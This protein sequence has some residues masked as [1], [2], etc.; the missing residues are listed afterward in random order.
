M[1]RRRVTGWQG[2]MCAAGLVWMLVGCE[3]AQPPPAPP[4][5]AVTVTHPIEREVIEWDEYT[6]R[7]D[8]VESVDVRARVS[9]LIES[10]SF[11]EGANVKKGDMLFT[12][13]VR[14]FRA[15]LNSK[16]ADVARAK[17]QLLQASSDLKRFQEAV[18]T[19]AVSAKDLDTAQAAFDRANAELAAARAAQDAAQLN[20][21]W[22]YITAP[23]DGRISN[24]RVDE[25]NL[26]T[27]GAGAATL[28][29]TIVSL[30]PIYCYVTVDENSVLKY[31]QLAREG[32]RVSARYAQIPTFL[33][34]ASETGFPHE[35]VVDFVD[36]QIDPTTGTVKGRGVYPNPDGFLQ[37]GMFAR[38]RIPGSGR[39]RALLI[40]DVAIGAD[41]NRRFVMTV[42]ADDIVEMHTVK[43]GALFGDLRA[44]ESGISKDDRV[45]IRGLQRARPGAKVNPTEQPIPESALA[46][47]A[48][49]SPTTQALPATR[50]V[51]TTLPSTMPTTSTAPAGAA[52]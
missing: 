11:K 48:P 50:R 1:M 27:G 26:I 23:I 49:G 37:P 20:V 36:N 35:G 24:K 40:P 15:E 17:A 5:P 25:G 28:L 13:D 52:R 2:M 39:Y 4:P 44:I 10:A 8:P 41:Q 30:N 38:V 45:V 12:I 31:A 47:T 51:S 22:C 9:G 6:G 19:S 7:L 32:K 21:D 14:P 43:L 46:R 18:K 33:A 16:I 3:G 42:K 34:V 29:T